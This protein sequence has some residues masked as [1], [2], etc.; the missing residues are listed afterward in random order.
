MQRILGAAL[1][2]IGLGVT[3]GCGGSTVPSPV[4][5]GLPSC[6]PEPP[7]RAVPL[8]PCPSRLEIDEINRDVPITFVND[9]SAGSLVCREEDG[10]ANLT[11]VQADT[12]MAMAFMRRKVFRMALPWTDKSAYDWFRGIVVG[13]VVEGGATGSASCCSPRG[14][15]HI[16][17]SRSD[18]FNPKWLSLDTASPAGLIHEARHIETGAHSCDY[19]DNTIAEMG[20]FGVQYYYTV[21]LANYSDEPE[22]MRAHWTWRAWAL[23][24]SA[25]CLE[26]FGS[27]ILSSQPPG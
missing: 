10:S 24:K 12:Y 1:A 6:G 26:C 19:R 4:L 8:A 16:V 21:W 22:D 9:P 18:P 3:V 7:D 15:I 2:A 14:V 25:F 13:I 23:R 5:S 11:Y 27:G 20:A 17:Y